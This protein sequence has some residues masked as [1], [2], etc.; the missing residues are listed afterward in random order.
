MDFMKLKITRMLE[1]PDQWVKLLVKDTD[2]NVPMSQIHKEDRFDYITT[3]DNSI[4]ITKFNICKI[5]DIEPDR[6]DGDWKTHPITIS[7][8]TR[9]EGL[10][11]A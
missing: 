6:I 3:I 10:T 4:A 11:S 9:E 2:D 5:L 7:Y 8:A 1:L